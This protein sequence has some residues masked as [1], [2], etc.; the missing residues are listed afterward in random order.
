MR[1]EYTRKSTNN[2][3]R[4]PPTDEVFFVQNAGAPAAGTGL[5]KSAIIEKVSLIGVSALSNLTDASD[6]VIVTTVD[7]D[8]TVIN[9]NGK[10]L[11]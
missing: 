7:S 4:F 11:I 8:P 9:P 6:L 2:K 5:K 1:P 3:N 10:V